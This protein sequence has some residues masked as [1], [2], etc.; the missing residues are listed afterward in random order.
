MPPE[1]VALIDKPW[2]LALI[3]ALGSVCGIFVE[4]VSEAEK[5]AKRRA[6]WQGRNGKQGGG[7]GGFRKGFRAVPLRG[8][9]ERANLDAAEQLRCVME[10]DF[11]PRALLNRPEAQVFKALDAAVIARNPGRQ[12]GASLTRR[13]PRQR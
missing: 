6:Y 7:K 11:T 4:R 5:R 8:T 13:I 12:D 10:A 3:L 9:P 2:L 1:I